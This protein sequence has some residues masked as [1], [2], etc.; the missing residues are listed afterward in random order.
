MTGM[1]MI[2]R[3]HS[4]KTQSGWIAVMRSLGARAAVL[5]VNTLAG[6][7]V[8]R[9]ILDHWGR[10]AYAE[11]GLLV[12]LSALLPFTDLGM[13]A[14]IMNAVGVS[15]DP[16]SDPA[17][18]LTIV[19]AVRVLTLSA[20]AISAVVAAIS[21]LRLWRPLLGHGLPAGPA[22]SAAAAICALLFAAGLPAGFGQ[23]ILIGLGRNATVILITALQGPMVLVAVLL[24]APAYGAGSYVALLPYGAA[25][26]L[27][28]ACVWMAARMIT[29]AVWRALSEV[30]KWRTRGAKVGHV[31]WPMLIQMIALPIAM[32]SDRIVLSQVSNPS[33]LAE[34][35]L[36]SQLFT[37][38]WAL[39]SAAGIAL[40]P[41][42]AKRRALG[43]DPA[44]SAQQ[45]ALLFAGAALAASACL[46]VLAPVL[47]P[48]ASANKVTLSAGVL[49]AFSIF[50]VLQAAKYPLG[51]YMT[52][53]RG[54]RFQ[55][56]MIVIF[57]PVNLG[58]SVVFAESDGAAGP[59]IG[60]IV[61]V[62]FCQVI[63]NWVFV[64]TRGFRSRA[65]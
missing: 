63:A 40:W 21:A 29:P 42:F 47:V 36:A 33:N 62:L 5:P 26:V 38:I 16:S 46:V 3:R 64:R 23:R 6:L 25:F 31:A 51:M 45:M 49:A 58:L 1:S 54:L 15:E 57:L 10:T 19:S 35:N 12:G 14:A 24:L 52:D 59:I 2:T 43:D 37:P 56:V 30:P 48:I 55:A 22:G 17:V 28:A 41:I 27:G 7:L 44:G 18:R 8:T 50:S 53:S 32:Q 4:G 60:S 13:S 20:L 61:G 39:V 11:Y 9:L 34:Y 65:A